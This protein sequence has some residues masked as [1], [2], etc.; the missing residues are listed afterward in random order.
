MHLSKNR[1]FLFTV[2]TLIWGT[3]F[4]LIKKSIAVYNPMQVGSLRVFI[5]GILL[6]YPGIQALKV[7]PRKIIF[8][9]VVT[10]FA[11]NFLPMYLFPM[12]QT[13]VSS[14]AAAILDSLVPIFVLIIGFLVFK[15]KNSIKQWIGVIIGFAG[16]WVII[17][18]QD[19]ASAEETSWYYALLIIIAAAS[20]AVSSLL[21]KRYLNEVPSL[22]LS[23]AIYSLWMWPALIVL[24]FTGFFNEF[25][26]TGVQWEGIG[27]VSILS[28]LGSAGAMILYY[29]LIQNSSAVFASS[30]TYVIP[31][32]AAGWGVLSGEELSWGHLIGGLL[33]LL[34][35]F[36]IQGKPAD[37]E[38]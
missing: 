36:L 7:L 14:S 31:I 11:G 23:A 15:Q 34:G 22:K 6:F 38:K 24:L 18:R 17:A 32:V 28:T 5:A 1:W 10:G 4:I 29:N 30:V 25:Q 2:L 37:I 19:G 21:L 20:Y 12:A 16:A 27:Y 3:S 9:A 13:K 8:W 33:I 26:G 35:I